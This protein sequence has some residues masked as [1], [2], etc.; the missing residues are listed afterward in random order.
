[1]NYKIAQSLVE[2]FK[3]NITVFSVNGTLKVKDP[4]GHLEELE[5]GSLREN[6]ERVLDFFSSKCIHSNAQIGF[7]SL[8]QQRLW[9]I[10]KIEPEKAQYNISGILELNGVLNFD[11]LNKSIKTILIYCAKFAI[12]FCR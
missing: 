8:Q 2:L 10:E 5:K 12:S 1:M 11:V 7:L 9:L 3:K 6:K 4:D